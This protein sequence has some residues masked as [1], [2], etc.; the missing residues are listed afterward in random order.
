MYFGF[1]N[2]QSLKVVS[3]TD[4]TEEGIDTCFKLLFS[5]DSCFNDVHPM[6]DSFSIEVTEA[7]IKI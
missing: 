6:N 7:G 5:N 1:K 3:S 4:V 2:G